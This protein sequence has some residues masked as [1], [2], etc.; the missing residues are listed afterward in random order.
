MLDP[1]KKFLADLLPKAIGWLTRWL[2]K[3]PK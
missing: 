1:F 2:K 3:A